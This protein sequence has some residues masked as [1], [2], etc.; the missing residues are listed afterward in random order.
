MV[1]PGADLRTVGPE[2]D[3]PERRDRSRRGF[4]SIV[5][6]Y[7]WS[8]LA[9]VAIFAVAGLLAAAAMPR[10]VRGAAR[11][12]VLQAAGGPSVGTTGDGLVTPAIEEGLRWEP[13]IL[14]LIRNAIR[15]TEVC[16]T[17]VPDGAIVNVCVGAANRDEARYDDPDHFDVFRRP[18]Q[19]VSFG[20]GPHMC[21]GMHLAR[22]ETTV[23]LNAVLD[24]LPNIRL[25]PDTIARLKTEGLNYRQIA[26]KLGV[27]ASKVSRTLAACA[28]KGVAEF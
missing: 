19:H 17:A 1:E 3:Q 5:R 28:L 7:R 24:R 25:D 27:S 4:G 13:P 22:M 8:I 14:F 26:K 2:E 11:V 10:H 9:L 20:W 12:L 18:H 6:A 23:A 16:G 15:D 21:I